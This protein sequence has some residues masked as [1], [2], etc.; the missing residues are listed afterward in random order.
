MCLN[1]QLSPRI[2]IYAS[3][4]E[5]YGATVTQLKAPIGAT[6]S[7]TDIENALKEKKYKVLTFTHVDTSTGMFLGVL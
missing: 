3:S 2:L 6:V 1:P 4:L 5:T 7:L